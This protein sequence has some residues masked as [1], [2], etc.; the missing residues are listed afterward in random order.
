MRVGRY[1][2]GVD[3]VLEHLSLDQSDADEQHSKQRKEGGTGQIGKDNE[4][5]PKDFPIHAI[6]QKVKKLR[7]VELPDVQGRDFADNRV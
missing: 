3:I 4:D 5:Y 6:I 1:I 2:V 7:G